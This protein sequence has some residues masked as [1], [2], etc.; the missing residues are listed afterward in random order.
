VKCAETR[1]RASTTGGKL[2][3][4]WPESFKGK[5]AKTEAEQ[6][7]ENEL[8]RLDP[9]VALVMG[10]GKRSEWRAAQRNPGPRAVGTS[11]ESA[12]NVTPTE[13]KASRP[14]AVDVL[15][16]KRG[17]RKTAKRRQDWTGL[18]WTVWICHAALPRL[19]VTISTGYR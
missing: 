19:Y 14:S 15:Y 4:S 12:G 18:D 1:S 7:M 3:L 9:S 11:W 13:E 2:V 17:K 6:R 10:A 16:I 5:A 8:S